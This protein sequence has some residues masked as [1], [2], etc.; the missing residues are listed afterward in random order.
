[1]MKLFKNEKGQG[2]VEFGLIIALVAVMAVFSLSAL[3]GGFNNLLTSTS[4]IAV[5]SGAPLVPI[6]E[7]IKTPSKSIKSE[8][9]SSKID[10]PIIR[11]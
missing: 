2:L 5:E 3:S 8:E 10:T 11:R 6:A 7:E 4:I 1:M 9:V